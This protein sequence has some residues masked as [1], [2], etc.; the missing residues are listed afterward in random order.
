MM[1]QST[2]TQRLITWLT[3]SPFMLFLA[4]AVL[5][6]LDLALGPYAFVDFY[7]T[8]EVHF[9]HFQNM[10]DLW[11]NY[12][13]F[14][15]YPFNAGGVPSFVGQHP[16][17]H[18]AV[19]L[20]MLMPVW[21]L[22]LLWNLGQM[23]LAGW[24]MY[25]LLRILFEI[26]DDVAFAIAAVFAM[27]FIGSN[28]HI[29]FAYA[30]PAYAVWTLNAFSSS[31]NRVK[32]LL[33]IFGLL[34]IS[35]LSFPVL[36]L[37]HFPAI[38]LALVLVFG[39]KRQDF[40]RQIAA[41]FLVW[42]GYVL[43]F[44]PSI[45]SLYQYIPFAQRDWGFP[46][47][48]VSHALT[49]LLAVFWAR[50]SELSTFPIV[51]FSLPLIRR[52]K[53]MTWTF[54]IITV[55]LII[56]A[57]FGS[58]AKN[59]L[60]NTFLVKMDLFLATMAAQTAA[61]LLAAQCLEYMKSTQR[62]PTICIILG[63]LAV[64]AVHGEYSKLRMLFIFVAW[65]ALLKLIR[66][67]TVGITKRRAV[68]LTALLAAGLAGMVMM[69]RQQYI[70]ATTFVPYARGYAPR[71]DMSALASESRMSP[72]R[73]AGVDVH[74]A[75]LQAYGLDTVGGKG[76][77][78][79]KYYK[80]YVRTAIAPQLES[81][82]I[83][84][85]FDSVWRQLYLTH[86]KNDHDQR[87][88]VE[89]GP[90]RSPA[91]FNIPLL[92][93]MNVRYVISS[94]PMRD[95]D[96]VADL[97]SVS[98]GGELP[99]WLQETWLGKRSVL[100]LWIYKLHEP[101]GLGS[102]RFARVVKDKSEITSWLLRASPE[103]ARGEL[104]YSLEMNPEAVSGFASGQIP[105]ASPGSASLVEWSPD[106]LTFACASDTDSWLYVPN[107]HAPNWLATVDGRPA[108]V[109]VANGAFQA[110]PIPAGHTKVEL[111]Y[112]NRILPWLLVVSLLGVALLCSG[113]MFPAESHGHTALPRTEKA[114]PLPFAPRVCICASFVTTLFWLTGYAFFM[115]RKVAV[116]APAYDSMTY[117]L[118]AIPILGLGV[119]VWT[120]LML[121]RI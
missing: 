24:G 1:E 47:V 2:Q 77:L 70:T 88:L 30:F 10:A 34:L 14:S 35:L 97:V 29:V 44:V 9:G 107:N 93:S 119:G 33:S 12:G 102:I 109:L 100:Q 32:K 114:Y 48:S 58:D 46:Q 19:F 45:V 15:W 99:K 17:Y 104:V 81:P 26:S 7:D 83:A 66:R 108:P 91:D 73:V 82:E 5:S 4:L 74:P 20:S 117:A 38:H 13:F 52:T 86:T 121:R 87:R 76:P 62:T 3:G 96:G 51:M 95:M 56:A 43:L 59:L 31:S 65:I 57:I 23:V 113:L 27:S 25:N 16:P 106:R 85:G 72:F 78:F 111:F 79:N 61:F 67:D 49:S 101:S 110:V 21:V 8:L 68:Q 55:S 39:N 53:S 92:K 69:D 105:P 84:K 63:V 41:V 42:T 75:I 80:Q 18:P 28:I 71:S 22:S 94:R 90:E 6:H 115:Y 37:P 98:A 118:V 116:T 89:N 112:S 40:V 36:T 64:V 11:R 60:A 54:C 120:S 103:Q 50:L